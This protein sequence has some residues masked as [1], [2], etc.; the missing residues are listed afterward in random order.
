MWAH[1][2]GRSLSDKVSNDELPHVVSEQPGW[3]ALVRAFGVKFVETSKNLSGL[4]RVAVS[5]NVSCL[6]DDVDIKLEALKTDLK[7][8]KKAVWASGTEGSIESDPKSFS[9][10][11]SIEELESFLW[12]METYF[13]AAKMPDAEKVSI[14]SMY[15]TGNANLWWCSHL[16]NDANTN[17]ERIETWEVLKKELKE[18][19]LLCN[20]SWVA[21]ESLWNLR[22]TG[23]FAQT[24]L[25]W[26][27]VKGLPLAIAAADR[28]ADFKVVNNLEQRKDDWGNGKAKSSKKFKK[29]EKA[30]KVVTESF[31]P[32]A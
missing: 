6:T 5:D 16:S 19:F 22:H 13:Q 31:E 27:G 17:R 29:K 24:E 30:T 3:L 32:R 7:V 14:T 10:D 15:L 21:R 26:Q 1:H 28:L 20:I 8:V 4:W 2:A 23:T 25:R 18:Q 9:G 11:W 12:D